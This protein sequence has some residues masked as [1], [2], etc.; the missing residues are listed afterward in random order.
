MNCKRKI[1]GNMP[2]YICSLMYSRNNQTEMY[3]WS[4]QPKCSKQT[5]TLTSVDPTYLPTMAFTQA[6]NYTGKCAIHADLLLQLESNC[7]Y[8]GSWA[9]IS[10]Y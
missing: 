4:M 6:C 10:A 5:L 7:I 1:N 3:L 8:V 2:V 9:C